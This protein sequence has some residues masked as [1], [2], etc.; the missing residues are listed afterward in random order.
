MFRNN[1]GHYRGK[2]E[3]LVGGRPSVSGSFGSYGI[4][5]DHSKPKKV[6]TILKIVAYSLGLSGSGWLLYFRIGGWK[7][8]ALWIILAGFWLVQMARACLKLYFE[9]K[10]GQIEL[11]EKRDRYKKDVF[12]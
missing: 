8:D 12:S 4:I 11:A 6:T 7:A 3:R 2:S 9:Y 10:E 5:I 1:N